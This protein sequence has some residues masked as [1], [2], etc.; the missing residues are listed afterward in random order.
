[1]LCGTP[2]GAGRLARMMN[3]S[4]TATF[5]KLIV[6]GQRDFNEEFVR[7][8]ELVTDLPPHWMDERREASE[9]PP[10]VQHAID[11][12]VPVAIFRGTAH[13]QPKR[14]VLCGPEPLLPQ[15]EATRRVADQAQQQ[16]KPR[17]T[18]RNCCFARIG[19]L[20]SQDLRRMER[21]LRL[22]QVESMQP[23]V[24]EPLASDRMSEAAKA[25]LSGRLEQVDKHVKL[26]HQHL[27]KADDAAVQFGRFQRR[28]ALTDAYW[29]LRSSLFPGSG[30]TV[31]GSLAGKVSSSVLSSNSSSSTG[32]GSFACGLPDILSS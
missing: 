32:F 8:I 30:C 25:D 16:S 21:Q 22:L 6:A 24:D 18:G 12:D 17:R 9:I 14:S 13:R 28:S 5:V 1:M 29:P 23:K 4:P 20:L 31:I 27:E 7:G 19:K 3:F 15:T 10:D 11:E 2:G 26:L